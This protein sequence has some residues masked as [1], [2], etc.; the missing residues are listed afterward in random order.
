MKQKTV[1]MLMLAIVLFLC[2]SAALADAET[3]GIPTVRLFIDAEELQKVNESPDH[4]YLGA[5][6]AV[7]IDVPEGYEGEFGEIDPETTAVDLPLAYIRGRGNSTWLE[8]KKSYKIKIENRTDLPGA[9]TGFRSRNGRTTRS[10]HPGRRYSR[11]DLRYMLVADRREGEPGDR[12]AGGRRGNAGQLDERSGAPLARVQGKHHERFLR[13][14]G[15]RA[16]LPGLLL[17]LL[18]PGEDRPEQLRHCAGGDGL[19]VRGLLFPQFSDRGRSVE[20]GG[21]KRRGYPVP[22][23]SRNGTGHALSKQ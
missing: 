3:N 23:M 4:S 2:F 18:Q 15:S 20:N 17:P 8:E 9:E 13:R 7:R 11:R 5:G 12:S 14:D 1:I 22:R 6:A 16:D 19:S 21:Q 10:R